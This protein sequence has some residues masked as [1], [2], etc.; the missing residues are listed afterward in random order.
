MGQSDDSGGCVSGFGALLDLIR[1]LRSE[2]GCPWDRKQTPGTFHHYILEEYHELVESINEGSSEGMIDEIGDL[3]FLVV[4]VA[5]MLEQE[6]HGSLRGV[7]DRVVEK[8]RRRH[9]HV[10]GGAPLQT[11]EQVVDNWSR[12][13]ASEENIRRRESILDGIPRTLPALT[14][15]HRIAQRAATVGFDWT[16]A[17]AVFPKIE[18]ELAELRHATR[19]GNP[20]AV[21][22][23]VGDLLFVLTNV[24]RHLGVNSEEALNET[25]DKFQRR[26]RHIEQSLHS[27]G[28]NPGEVS[29]E[30]MDRLW[31][32]AKLTE[33]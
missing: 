8:M 31:E 20:D 4:F 23:E 24:A 7:L 30:E 6:G 18:E 25:S 12:I 21:R 26:F 2:N 3:I 33:S 28:K 11:P 10:F 15:A 16:D 32:E 19:N 1:S 17:W 14:R 29:L 5:Y 13:K 22:E 9:P 27:R